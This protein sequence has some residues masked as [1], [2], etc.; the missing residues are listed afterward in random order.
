ML[1]YILTSLY[2]LLFTL[3]MRGSIDTQEVLVLG[4]NLKTAEKFINDYM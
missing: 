3:K 4:D 1:P 2:H